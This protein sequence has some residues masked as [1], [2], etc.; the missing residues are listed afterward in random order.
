M[1]M[2]I[3][4]LIIIIFGFVI[5]IIRKEDLTE[6]KIDLEEKLEEKKTWSQQ[7][8]MSYSE[9]KKAK[10]DLH[11]VIDKNIVGEKEGNLLREIVDEWA[12]LKVQSF[13]E[14]RSWVRRPEETEE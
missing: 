12:E 2:L 5:Y 13:Q 6:V 14:R 8:F 3:V 4:F 1:E 10:A 7:K 9:V 11:I